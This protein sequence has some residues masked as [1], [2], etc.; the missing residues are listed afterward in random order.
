[1]LFSQFEEVLPHWFDSNG[2]VTNSEVEEFQKIRQLSS[3]IEGWLSEEQGVAL[4]QLARC[5]IP[6]E[7]LEIGSFC[8]KSTIFLALGCKQSGTIVHAIDPHKAISEGGKEQYAQDFSPRSK[9]TLKDFEDNLKKSGLESFVKPMICTSEEARYKLPPLTL[10]LL[11]I[12]GSHDYLDVV[13]DYYLWHE[14][15]VP[16]GYLVFHDSNFESVN[17]MIQRHVNQERYSLEGVIGE[18]AWGMTIWRCQS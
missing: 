5:Q 10:K 16:G 3:N 12:D 1:M 9:G 13:L 4:Y 2:G 17:L 8:G 7:V 14:Q 11:F 6:G 18:G 15:V